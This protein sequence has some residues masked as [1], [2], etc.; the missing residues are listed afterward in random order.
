MK[1]LRRPEPQDEHS[2]L[3]VT[4]NLGFR[5]PV[6]KISDMIEHYAYADVP[7]GCFGLNVMIAMSYQYF[8][9]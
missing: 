5:F 6:S 3:Y 9:S 8:V 4:S 2:T 1:K 7:L